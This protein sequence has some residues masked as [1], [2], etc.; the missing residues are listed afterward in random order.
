MTAPEIVWCRGDELT[1]AQLY[2]LIVLRVDIFV[3]EQ[4]CAYAETDG[5]DLAAST[6]HGWITDDAGAM[7]A[8]VRL[9]TDHEPP[10]IGRVA[11]RSDQRQKGLAAALVLAAHDRCHGAS[12]L[13]AQSYLVGWYEQLGWS[14]AGDE[15]VED[16]IPHMPMQRTDSA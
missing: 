11:T 14:V 2:E 12:F 5:K 4:E 9:L 1:A 7:A 15:F 16:G 8:T 3:V 13:E 10:Q 6:W